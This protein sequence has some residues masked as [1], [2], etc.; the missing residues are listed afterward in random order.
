MLPSFHLQCYDEHLSHANKVLLIQKNTNKKKL[1][2]KAN[3]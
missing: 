3:Q 2:G 1:K